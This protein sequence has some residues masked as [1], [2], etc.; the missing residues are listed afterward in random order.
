MAKGNICAM[1]S[2]KSLLWV[3]VFESKVAE[4]KGTSEIKLIFS[5]IKGLDLQKAQALQIQA[6]KSLKSSAR[7][8]LPLQLCVGAQATAVH[9]CPTAVP[10]KAAMLRGTHLK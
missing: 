8:L 9:G 1:T 7:C 6:L 3:I 10:T 4:L 2:G 5:S